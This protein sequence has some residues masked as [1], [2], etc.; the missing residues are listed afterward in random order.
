M[1]IDDRNTFCLFLPLITRLT[2]RETL[3]VD[4]YPQSG[5]LCDCSNLWS[6]FVNNFAAFWDGGRQKSWRTKFELGQS[7]EINLRVGGVE[8]AVALAHKKLNNC[9]PRNGKVRSYQHLLC[10]TGNRPKLHQGP[11]TQLN[12]ITHFALNSKYQEIDPIGITLRHLERS[13]PALLAIWN[14]FPASEFP[15]HL[16]TWPDVE[17]FPCP[18]EAKTQS[19]SLKWNWVFFHNC[20]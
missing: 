8:I 10:Q 14:L 15:P 6:A 16:T 11:S 19:R 5:W 2:N 9:P 12:W 1:Q 18:H 4:T 7:R 17:Y 20:F 13:V 3:K